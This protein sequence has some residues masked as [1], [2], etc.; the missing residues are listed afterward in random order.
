[1]LIR[2]FFST[3]RHFVELVLEK[4]ISEFSGNLKQIQNVFNSNLGVQFGRS[5]F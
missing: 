2:Q 3:V 4:Q 1:M 5:I